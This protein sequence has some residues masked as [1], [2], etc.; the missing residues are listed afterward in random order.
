VANTRRGAGDLEAE[1][2]SI[3]WGAQ[4]PLTSAEIL[5]ALGGNLAY[6]TVQ[7]TLSR[8]LSKGAVLREQSG[9]AHAYTPVLNDAGMAARRMRAMLDRGKDREAV[10]SQFVD[11]LTPDEEDTLSHLLRKQ[12]AAEG[13]P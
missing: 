12:R 10:L 9:R 3:L 8:L 5:G 2:L 11:T 6:T 13:E 7:T 4:G 1:I